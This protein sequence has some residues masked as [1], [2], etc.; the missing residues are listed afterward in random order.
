MAD[1][2]EMFYRF[3]GILSEDPD[4]ARDEEGRKIAS[5][6]DEDAVAFGYHNGDMLV[7]RGTHGEMK[8]WETGE[9]V[10]SRDKLK[11]PGR[12]WRN[13]KLISFWEFPPRNKL[14]KVMKDVEKA[15]N[16]R[17]DTRGEQVRIGK[18]WKVE[19]PDSVLG[20]G[21]A[22]ATGGELNRIWSFDDSEK[23]YLYP[24]SDIVSGKPLKGIGA[25]W[26]D[27]KMN[28]D[29]GKQHMASP[30]K[31]KIDKLSSRQKKDLWNY[32]KTLRDPSPADKA[33]YRFI[34]RDR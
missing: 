27:L 34:Q 12:L 31:K 10:R 21:G 20:G 13:S 5:W 7:S 24:I 3:K 11:Y 23:S 4:I 30:V 8:N 1:F 22:V 19:V 18:D 6:P 33:L 9:M 28:V 2:H 16:S 29:T 26:K 15:W 25:L 32:Y 17:K 14:V